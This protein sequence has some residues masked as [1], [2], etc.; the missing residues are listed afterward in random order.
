MS[1]EVAKS[2][3][4][5]R[6]GCLKARTIRSRG[7]PAATSSLG[8]PVLGPVVLDPD[9]AAADVDVEHGPWIR[10]CPPSRVHQLVVIVRLVEDRP[11]PRPRRPSGLC[12]FDDQVADD[13]RSASSSIGR[14]CPRRRGT[15]SR[16]SS[17][18]RRRRSP[19]NVLEGISGTAGKSLGSSRISERRRCYPRPARSLESDGP[20]KLLI[21]TD[22]PPRSAARTLRTGSTQSIRFRRP[23]SRVVRDRQPSVDRGRASRASW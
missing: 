6:L 18:E 11:R 22:R 20:R 12:V 7:M 1:Q 13:R 8:D 4:G 17:L 21:S 23:S 2:V 14:S 16:T 5:R 19:R 15:P 3:R 9:L 10:R